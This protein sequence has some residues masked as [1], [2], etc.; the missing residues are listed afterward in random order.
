[1][2]FLELDIDPSTKPWRKRRRTAMEW[3]EK[4]GGNMAC[5]MG[6]V[7]VRVQNHSKVELGSV[8]HDED[9]DKFKRRY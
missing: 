1:V 2:N 7:V 4:Q 8:K 3:R 5:V 9:S 6:Q